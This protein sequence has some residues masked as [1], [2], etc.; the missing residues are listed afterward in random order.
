MN[1]DHQ[2]SSRLADEIDRLTASVQRW[3]M[4]TALAFAAL[5]ILLSYLRCSAK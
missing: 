1:L 5:V 3:R 2:Y 4:V